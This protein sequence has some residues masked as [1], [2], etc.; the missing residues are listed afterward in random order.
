[1]TAADVGLTMAARLQ[2]AGVEKSISRKRRSQILGRPQQSR[3]MDGSDDTGTTP[4]L[5]EPSIR[6]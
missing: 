3:R 4:W 6:Q 5:N 2:D 1:M